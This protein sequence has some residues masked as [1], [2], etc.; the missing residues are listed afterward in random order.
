MCNLSFP[1]ERLISGN[2]S[3]T[4]VHSLRGRAEAEAEHR[5]RAHELEL[6]ALSDPSIFHHDVVSIFNERWLLIIITLD[7]SLDSPQTCRHS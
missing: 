6:Q 3:L 7:L 2:R 5:T 1:V 4:S